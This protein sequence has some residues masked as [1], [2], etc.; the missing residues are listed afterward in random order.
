ME[1]VVYLAILFGIVAIMLF[2]KKKLIESFKFNK[3]IVFITILISIVVAFIGIANPTAMDNEK[4]LELWGILSIIITVLHAY[5]IRTNLIFGWD[6]YGT[7]DVDNWDGKVEVTIEDVGTEYNP[8]LKGSVKPIYNKVG[9]GTVII[10][11]II[12]AA[13]DVAAV[14][15]L[16]AK[17]FWFVIPAYL[18]I[19]NIIKIL[20]H[21]SS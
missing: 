11:L 7:D 20:Q 21:K 2:I 14:Y 1:I 3:A 12:S 18:I 16:K 8:K 17:V 10:A 9:S 19:S 15:Y 5:A 4:D 13:F 6:D